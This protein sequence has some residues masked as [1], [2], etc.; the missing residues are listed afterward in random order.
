MVLFFSCK[1]KHSSINHEKYI[2]I[3]QEKILNYQ[4]LTYK[5]DSDTILAVISSDAFR[6]CG[7]SNFKK[8]NDTTYK[9]VASVGSESIHIKFYYKTKTIK[10]LEVKTGNFKPG[11]FNGAVYSYKS[12]PFFIDDC[13][14]MK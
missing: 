2:L 5:K 7:K 11:E 1:S 6:L 3:D 4:L 10:G 14:P 9:K 13:K 12:Y 8:L